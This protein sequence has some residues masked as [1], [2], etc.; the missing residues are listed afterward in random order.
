MR[1]WP[2][3][4]AS[5]AGPNPTADSLTSPSPTASWKAARDTRW[6]QSTVPFWKTLPSPTPPCATCTRDPSSCGWDRVYA[7]E[8]VK[9]SNIYFESS[10]GGTAEDAKAQPTEQED[11][12]PDPGR[13]G[14]TPSSGFYLRHMKNLEMSH[15]EIANTTPDVTPAF[16]LSGVERADFFAITAPR[17]A[18]GAFSLHNVKVLRIGW[19]RAA[20]D[21]TLASVDDKVL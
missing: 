13:F 3:M 19:S 18:D 15:V 1:S 20:A 17:G 6:S 9:L 11:N 7:V 14:V 12:Y 4:A 21:T 10:G 5:S 2:T 8:D 16:Y